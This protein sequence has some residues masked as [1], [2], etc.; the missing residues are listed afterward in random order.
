MEGKIIRTETFNPK[1]VTMDGLFGY[2]CKEEGKWKDGYVTKVFREYIK[3][4][5][6]DEQWLIFD[7]PID[8]IW[9]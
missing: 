6:S 7:G 5:K 9:V 2:Y 1:S 4:T 3:D 8:A